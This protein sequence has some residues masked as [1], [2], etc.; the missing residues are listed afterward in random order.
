MSSL[1]SSNNLRKIPCT[2]RVI[3]HIFGLSTR[4]KHKCESALASNF[5]LQHTDNQ[6]GKKNFKDYLERMQEKKC[7]KSSKIKKSLKKF[8][9]GS[10]ENS[11]FI[12]FAFRLRI[13]L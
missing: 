8:V 11:F 5:F 13:N 7:C 2:M 6:K 3:S 4:E 9:G 1:V 10:N 12:N